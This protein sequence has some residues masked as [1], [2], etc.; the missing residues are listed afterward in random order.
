MRKQHDAELCERIRELE[1]R[2]EELEA[3]SQT[4]YVWNPPHWCWV[5]CPEHYPTITW[6]T[7]GTTWS[8]PPNTTTY[9]KGVS[10]DSSIYTVGDIS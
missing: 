1:R 7:S 2:V 5:G 6:G 10:T 4:T 9:A 8:P 3:R